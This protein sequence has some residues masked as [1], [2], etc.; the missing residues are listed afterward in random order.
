MSEEP[1]VQPRVD[2]IILG[3]TGFTGQYA[4]EDLIKSVDK[5]NAGLTWAVAGRNEAKLRQVL[6]TTS[7]CM[8]KSLEEVPIVVTDVN[9]YASVLA[10]ARRARVVVNCVGPYRFYGENVVK[11]CIE[12]IICST[13]RYFAASAWRWPVKVTSS[14]GSNCCLGQRR[15]DEGLASDDLDLN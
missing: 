1:G 5:E 8:S 7:K 3:A 12:V 2:L 13:H 14:R 15:R 11:A 4:V 6:D 9:D 10:M